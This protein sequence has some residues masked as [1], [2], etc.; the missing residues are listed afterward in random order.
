MMNFTRNRLK[1]HLNQ[2]AKHRD[3][4]VLRGPAAYARSKFQ[5]ILA[6]PLHSQR[7]LGFGKDEAGAADPQVVGDGSEFVGFANQV[8]GQV[9]DYFEGFVFVEAVFA[10]EAAEEGAV[11]AAGYVVAG[12]DGEKG[13]GVVVEAYGVVEAG[14]L[15]GLFAEAHHALGGVVEPPGRTEFERGIVAGERGELTGVGGLV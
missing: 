7:R 2:I 4:E 1:P 6:A 15:G 11:D 5:T 9:E 12:G 3:R 14:G 13:A 8:D 10:Y